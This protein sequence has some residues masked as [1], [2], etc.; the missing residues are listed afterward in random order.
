MNLEAQQT[1]S[2]ANGRLWGL[3]AEDW[4]ELQE[5]TC[6]PVYQAVFD[7][8]AL[9]AG[10]HYLD[11]GCGAGLA[12]QMA[13]ERGAHVAGLDAAQN[14]VAIA[15]SRTPTGEFSVG[16]LERPPFVDARFDLVTGFNSLQYAAHPDVAL[17]EAKRLAKSGGSV[18]IMT[19]G[20]PNGMEAASLVA[21]LKPL[22]PSAPP[23]A[24]GPF[25]LSDRTVLTAF[26]E[27]AGLVVEEILDVPSPWQ[28]ADL[29][30]AIRALNS[31]GVA[32]RAAEH[33][34]REAVTTAHRNALAP[35][36][37]ADGSYRVQA[38]FR[39]LLA[40]S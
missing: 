32:A 39:C 28:Y 1:S 18:V 4:A 26:A 16:E 37:Q 5:P 30:T 15:K 35:F 31:S 23:G 21:A 6:R 27:R 38:T 25:A 11:L 10:Q 9:S 24:P 13:A 2:T 3:A 20:D 7:R 14:L 22:M 17:K 36:R 19:W 34:G 40:R 33:S 29:D 12:A 8:V